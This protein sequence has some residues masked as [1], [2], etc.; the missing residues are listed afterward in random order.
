M[1]S[2]L[3]FAC[4]SAAAIFVLMASLPR[5]VTAPGFFEADAGVAIILPSRRGTVSKMFVRE[6]QKVEPGTILATIRVEEDTAAAQT[7]NDMV[8]SALEAQK[9][10]LDIQQKSAVAASVAQRNQLLAQRSG[11]VLEIAEL[12][13]QLE[14]QAQLIASSQ[15]DLDRIQPVADQGYISVRDLQSRRDALLTR[16]MG[17]AVLK[18]T[19]AVKLAHVNE[20]ARNIQETD[21]RLAADSAQLMS[22]GAAI[23]KEIANTEGLRSYAIRSPIAGTISGLDAHIGQAVDTSATLMMVFPKRSKISAKLHIPP[24]SIGFLKPGQAVAICIDAFPCRSYGS[25]RGT[26][27]KV[28]LGAP[29]SLPSANGGAANFVVTVEPAIGDVQHFKRIGSV[30]PGM[31]FRADIYTGRQSFF[32]SAFIFRRDSR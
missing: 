20:I 4:V 23:A 25:M 32:G 2:C 8:R 6:G 7:S 18:Q 5:T 3:L 9:S 28:A 21:A 16:R 31:T 11:A 17:L 26:V 27:A 1:V 22:S 14:L 29:T 30:M 24:S 13:G 19:L 10:S 15:K 12:Q